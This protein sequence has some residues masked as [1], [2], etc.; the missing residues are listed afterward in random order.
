MRKAEFIFG[1]L[2][3]LQILSNS[4]YVSDFSWFNRKKKTV[5]LILCVSSTC[6]ASLVTFFLESLQI[7][8]LLN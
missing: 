7:P 4:Q 5:E 3:K 1:H 6:I 8:L 2:E